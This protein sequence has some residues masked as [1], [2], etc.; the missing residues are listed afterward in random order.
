MNI[1]PTPHIPRPGVGEPV[2]PQ[3]K[4]EEKFWDK[5]EKE[6]SG[7]PQEWTPETVILLLQGS[8][9]NTPYSDVADAHNAANQ[10]AYDKGYEDCRKLWKQELEVERENWRVAVGNLA[11][12]A[13]ENADQLAAERKKV[14]ELVGLLER[15]AEIYPH[16][17]NLK[18]A[19][20]KVKEAK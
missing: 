15:V 7:Q 4:E 18:D 16:L 8:Q 13:R 10:A 17:T 20:A 5:A 3:S 14:K 11:T 12:I 2:W 19:L 1:P 6:A 9:R